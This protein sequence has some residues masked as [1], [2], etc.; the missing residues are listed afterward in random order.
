MNRGS[1]QQPWSSASLVIIGNEQK[2]SKNYSLKI[3][4]LNTDILRGRVGEVP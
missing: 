2:F 4:T 1:Y 3:I